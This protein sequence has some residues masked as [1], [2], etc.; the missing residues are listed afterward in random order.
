MLEPADFLRGLVRLGVLGDD[1]IPLPLAWE[2]CRLLDSAFDGRVNLRAIGRG[3]T[4]ART[5]RL[6]RLGRTTPSVVARPPGAVQA[7]RPGAAGTKADARYHESVCVEIVKVEKN[8]RSIFNF[9]RSFKRFITQ[10]K[11][12]LEQNGFVDT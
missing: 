10:Q 8:A 6:R 1:D 11:T 2:A 9:D 7:R 4:E 5:Q 3:V 12:L